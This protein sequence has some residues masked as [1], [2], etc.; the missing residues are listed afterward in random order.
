VNRYLRLELYAAVA[1]FGLA[2]IAGLYLAIATFAQHEACYG[3]VAGKLTCQ[4]LVPGSLEYAQAAGRAA[5]VLSTV[6]AL[7]GIGALGAWWQSRTKDPSARTTAYMLVVS[8]ALLDLAI[9]L[10]AIGGVGFYFIPS[11][12]LALVTAVLG[13]VA[14]IQI[15]RSRATPIAT[16]APPQPSASSSHTD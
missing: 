14:L 5:F 10:P 3:M 11:T 15:A 2:L 6:L 7:Y 16:A 13:L 9:T 1:A 12:I 8:C 4:T